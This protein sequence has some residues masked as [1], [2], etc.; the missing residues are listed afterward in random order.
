MS[1]TKLFLTEAISEAKLEA[2]KKL[3]YKLFVSQTYID[4]LKNDNMYNEYWVFEMYLNPILKLDPTPN[5]QYSTWLIKT[6]YTDA[7]YKAKPIYNV[8]RLREDTEK[9][10]E[11]LQAHFNLK[12][13]KEFPQEFKDINKIKSFDQLNDIIKPFKV[14]YTTM[15]FDQLIKS[16]LA[17]KEVDYEVFYEDEVCGIYTLLTEK[18]ACVLGTNSD[19]C[20]SFGSLSPREDKRSKSNYFESY[21]NEG[22]LYVVW[23]KKTNEIYQIDFT[24]SQ[25]MN[26]DDRDVGFEF[27]FNQLSNEARKFWKDAIY[28]VA[29]EFTSIKFVDDKPYL[30]FTDWSEFGNEFVNTE[31]NIDYYLGD[32]HD[33]YNNVDI[34]D[35]TQINK[36][37]LEPILN[38]VKEVYDEVNIEDFED[39][40]DYIPF[41]KLD[42]ISVD[43]LL[44]YIWLLSEDIDIHI[45]KEMVR[46]IEIAVSEAQSSAD[47]SEAFYSILNNAFENYG[48]TFD[49]I[50]DYIKWTNNSLLVPLEDSDGDVYAG[51][52]SY[53]V[54]DDKDMWKS[55][56]KKYHT[57]YYGFDGDIDSEYLKEQLEYRLSEI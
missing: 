7:K 53:I 51:V 16:D 55:N 32:E 8:D 49:A 45:F 14:D 6:I 15:T 18:G 31:A 12:Q 38:K 28:Q 1:L 42:N 21:N 41:E 11:N 47:K 56:L 39:E 37:H 30:E 10:K 35:I 23:I 5:N 46:E 19:W 54:T 33:Y 17:K 48:T 4:S 25:Y 26:K 20:T 50:K 36:E 22:T 27:I 3:F 43:D 52:L 57:P 44:N 13:R 9:I 2:L 40:D 24:T 34:L 29:T